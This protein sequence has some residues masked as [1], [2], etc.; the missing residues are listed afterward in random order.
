STIIMSTAVILS[1][2]TAIHASNS[3]GTSYLQQHFA[4]TSG[5]TQD[6]IAIALGANGI[7][8]SAGNT[9]NPS[10]TDLER[11]ILANSA[12]SKNTPELATKL[13]ATYNN[14]HI[15][16]PK[17]LNADIF[18]VLALQAADPNWLQI[19]LS[20]LATIASSQQSD[21]SFNFAT[22]GEGSVDMTAAALWALHI[23]PTNYQ[24]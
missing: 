11:M 1:L 16:D 15:G 12:Q 10:V 18:G 4:A 21:G 14:N 13:E 17:L 20:I 3:P 24:A 2:S 8:S 9:N 22:T 5:D 7:S 19:H 23:A 6:W